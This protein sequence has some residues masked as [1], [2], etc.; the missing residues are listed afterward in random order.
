MPYRGIE[1]SSEFPK[2]LWIQRKP[3]RIS[4]TDLNTLPVQA[5][6]IP[7]QQNTES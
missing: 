6:Y 4:K 7:S 1:N 5:C 2:S 3:V